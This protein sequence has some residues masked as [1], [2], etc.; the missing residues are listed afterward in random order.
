MTQPARGDR[1]EHVTGLTLWLRVLAAHLHDMPLATGSPMA[2][3][4]CWEV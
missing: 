1:G 4:T 3:G 2:L